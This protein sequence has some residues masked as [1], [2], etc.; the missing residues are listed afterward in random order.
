M[1][2]LRV[3]IH[4]VWSTKK[5]KPLMT[6]NIRRQIF[7]HIRENAK[8]KNIHLDFINGYTE[9]VHCLISMNA[10]QTLAEIAQLIK[11]ESSFWINKNKLTREKFGWQRRYWAVSVSHSDVDRV[12]D[13]IK[14]QESHHQQQTYAK[15]VDE[16]VEKFGFEEFFDDE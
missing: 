5:R 13:Y 14:N 11:G 3:W 10:N 2:H 4:Y 6:K 16:I 9:H 8:T 7:D 12:R 1:P 15:E